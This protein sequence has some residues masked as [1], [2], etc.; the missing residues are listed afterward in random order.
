M[1]NWGEIFPM[2]EIGWLD[3]GITRLRPVQVFCL[4]FCF[5]FVFVVVGVFLFNI[6]IYIYIYFIL[7][8]LK[9]LFK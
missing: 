1:E 6:Y 7:E 8:F 4:L 5:V 2:P 3:M 9:L